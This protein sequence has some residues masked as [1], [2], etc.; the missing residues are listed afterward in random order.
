MTRAN[1][2]LLILQVLFLL[3]TTP[4]LLAVAWLSV[5]DQR[6]LVAWTLVY[7]TSLW[8]IGLLMSFADER[9]ARPGAVSLLLAVTLPYAVLWISS[10]IP[11]QFEERAGL[12]VFVATIAAALLGY[13]LPLWFRPSQ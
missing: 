4:V 7:S 9:V 3:P 13:W 11:H 5:A 12:V 10:G 8:L 2:P 1:I 6:M